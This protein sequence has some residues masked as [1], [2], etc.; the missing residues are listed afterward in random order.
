MGG[1][2]S[3]AGGSLDDVAGVFPQIF[4]LLRQGEGGEESIRRLTRVEIGASDTL[5]RHFSAV[6]ESVIVIE[7]F[8]RGHVG[9]GNDELT[10]QHLGIRLFNSAAGAVQ[11]LMSGYYQNSVMSQRDLVEVTFLLDYFRSNKNQ[12]SEWRRSPQK[13]TPDMVR[14]ALDHRDG[15]T[16]RK[17]RDHYKLLSGIGAHASYQGFE[18]LRPNEGSDACCGPFFAERLLSPATEELAKACILAA[19]AF[20][21]QFKPRSLADFEAMIRFTEVKAAWFE[22]FIGPFDKSGLD[23]MRAVVVRLRSASAIGSP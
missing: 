22:R 20:L 21:F 2:V 23:K 16:E 17:R 3:N 6:A 11:S 10:I 1:E 8:V 14:K 13:F 4:D 9:T 12:I 7:H 5:L 18:L 15:F 19:E